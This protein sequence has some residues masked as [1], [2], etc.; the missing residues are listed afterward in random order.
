MALP[1]RW[2]SGFAY[3]MSTLAI[4]EEIAKRNGHHT[5]IDKFQMD[6]LG[7]ETAWTL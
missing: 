2:K 4:V 3:G 6:R 7:A 1:T 5:V